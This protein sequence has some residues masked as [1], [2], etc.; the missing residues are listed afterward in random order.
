MESHILGKTGRYSRWCVDVKTPR[1]QRSAGRELRDYILKD[2]P[3]C[4]I[5]NTGSI[6]NLDTRPSFFMRR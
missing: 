3:R 5:L 1:L 6:S 2:A 4:G